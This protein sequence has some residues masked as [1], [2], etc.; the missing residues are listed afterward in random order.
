MSL[1]AMGHLLQTVKQPLRVQDM[2]ER[3]G[4]SHELAQR[5]LNHWLRTGLV[6]KIEDICLEGKCQ[7]CPL[8]CHAYY[9]WVMDG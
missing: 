3:L 9:G 5:Y 2:A 7:D 6:E 4:I 1:E 8:I